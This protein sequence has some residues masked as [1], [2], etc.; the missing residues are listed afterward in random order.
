LLA[1]VEHA[2]KILCQDLDPEFIETI[3]LNAAWEY[4]ALYERLADDPNLVDDYRE[5]EFLKRRGD[6]AVRALA[7]AASQHGVPAEFRRLECNGQRKLL[8]K[9][10]RV[11]IIQEPILSLSAQPSA[12]DYKRQ[13]ADLHGF[14]RQ[15][16]LD[17][18]D[19]PHRV[20]DWSGC[21]LAALLHGPAG[22]SFN[23]E[24]K[25]LGSIM[26]GV[27]DADYQQWVLRIDLHTIAMFGRNAAPQTEADESV[28]QPDNVVVTPRKRVAKDT[29]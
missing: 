15:L 18:G 12:A 29:A 6:C 24:D 21:V 7:R 22:R 23:R 4:S 2:Q 13:L 17:L 25:A 1:S 14:V 3:S 16:E 8:V 11:L 19:Q 27:P 5:E 9:A 26:L 20:R 10:S 28:A